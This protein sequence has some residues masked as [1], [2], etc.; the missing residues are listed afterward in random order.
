MGIDCLVERMNLAIII[1]AHNEENRI[2]KTLAAYSSY[3]SYLARKKILNYMLLIV[4]NSTTDR[5][6]EIVK[7]AMRKESRMQCL[8]RQGEG[9]GY[10]VLEGFRSALEK[11]Y[12]CIGFVDADGAISPR[13]FYKLVKHLGKKKF[14]AAI[15][16]RYLKGSIVKPQP[17]PRIVASRLYNLIARVLFFMPYRDTQ[18]GAKVFR[19]RSLSAIISKPISLAWSFDVD[20]LYYLRKKGYSISEVPIRWTDKKNSK[21]N[22]F[23]NGLHMIYSLI[24]T[25]LLN[26]PLMP[27]FSHKTL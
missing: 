19:S 8:I 15:G 14:D 12:D 16:S 26:S 9:K 10:A 24:Y 4:I 27:L 11:N 3:F 2:G 22:L 20:M 6:E 13:E 21:F 25:R 5:T 23:R 18:C 7:K 17:L 1:P